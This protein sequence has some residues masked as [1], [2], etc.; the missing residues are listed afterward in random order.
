MNL[1]RRRKIKFARILRDYPY[2]RKDINRLDNLDLT[3][4]YIKIRKKQSIQPRQMRDLIR[5]VYENKEKLKIEDQI[6]QEKK[7]S[8]WIK[9]FFQWIKKL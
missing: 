6:K 3:D 1:S 8:N 4:E 9:R 2:S 7:K 5:F